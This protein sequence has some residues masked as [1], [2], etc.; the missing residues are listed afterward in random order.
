MFILILQ[1]SYHIIFILVRISTKTSE[2]LQIEYRTAM[3]I[4][5]EIKRLFNIKVEDSLVILHNV[6]QSL[7]NLSSGHYIMR[8]TVRNGAFATV[9]KVA[10]N[11]G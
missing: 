6:I 3:S 9:F 5:N 11:P 10:E 8:H 1:I 2:I 7:T 4:N